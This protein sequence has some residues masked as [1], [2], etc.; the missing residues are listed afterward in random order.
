MRKRIFKLVII[1]GLIMSWIFFKLVFLKPP[2]YYDISGWLSWLALGILLISSTISSW[3]RKVYLY[4]G[5]LLMSLGALFNILFRESFE[6]FEAKV[7][8][9]AFLFFVAGIIMIF[10]EHSHVS[11]K[12]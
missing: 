10:F 6:V 11:K 12:K 5:F 1:L 2:I 4:L 7:F 3:L 8:N 9:F